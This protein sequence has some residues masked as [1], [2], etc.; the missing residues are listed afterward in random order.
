MTPTFN[1]FD[2]GYYIGMVNRAIRLAEKRESKLTHRQ[3][4]PVR[5]H[6]LWV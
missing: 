2:A 1:P 4:F 6:E 5:G 3:L